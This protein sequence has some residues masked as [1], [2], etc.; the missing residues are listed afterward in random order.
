MEACINT[1]K[2]KEIETIKNL[3]IKKGFEVEILESKTFKNITK[4]QIPLVHG[5]NEVDAIM[6][7]MQNGCGSFM[8]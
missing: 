1:T 3:L 6:I 5:T 2:I 4:I 8:R 7:C